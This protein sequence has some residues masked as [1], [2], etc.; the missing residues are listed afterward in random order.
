MAFDLYFT[1]H[2]AAKLDELESDPAFQKRLKSVRK[3]LGYLEANPR[4]PGLNTYKYTSLAGPNGEE[5][6][7]A[8]AEN[9]TP[10]AYRIFWFY[11]PE[12]SAITIVD[13]TPHP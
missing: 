3:A 7:E 2:A 8:Y 13:I 11:G 4:H 5:V 9:N 12:K 6:F 10:G 1:D